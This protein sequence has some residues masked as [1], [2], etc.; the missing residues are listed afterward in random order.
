MGSQGIIHVGKQAV[1][2]VGDTSEV[3]EPGPGHSEGISAG[4][5]E[6]IDVV[7]NGGEVSSPGSA[8]LTVVELIFGFLESQRQGN[9]RVELPLP[10][11]LLDP[12]DSQLK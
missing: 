10:R 6:L 2:S 1:L 5:R 12:S 7:A 9:V 11:D 8:G 4:V 3:I